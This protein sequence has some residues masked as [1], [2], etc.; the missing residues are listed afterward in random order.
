MSPAQALTY[1]LRRGAGAAWA[2]GIPLLLLFPLT[3]V[4]VF[5]YAVQATRASLAA[6]MAPPPH[7]RLDRRLLIDGLLSAGL[8]LSISLPFGLVAWPLG[9]AIEMSNVLQAVGDPFLERAFAVLAAGMA[10]ALPWGLAMLLLV[11]PNLAAYAGGGGP[12]DLFSPARALARVRAHLLDWN[13]ASAAI[14]TAWALGLAAGGLLCIGLLPGAFY[15]I[16][17]S[18]HATATL[19]RPPPARQ[20][21]R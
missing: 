4:L 13:L 20:D 19:A 11:P 9:A 16:L 14:V 1:P 6:P 12:A 18:A 5:G 21:A 8:V 3:F 10:L 17:V 15:A 2:A 7:F